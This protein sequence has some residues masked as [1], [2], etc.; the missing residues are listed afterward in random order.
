MSVTPAVLFVSTLVKT[1][2][3]FLMIQEGKNNYNQY[4]KWN[5]PSGHVELG[6]TM[7][8]AAIREVKEE[9]GYDVRLD[10]LVT[11]QKKDFSDEIGLV[12]FFAGSLLSNGRTASEDD[13]MNIDF[14]SIKEIE[15]ID[16][17]FPDL[18][19][20]AKI[21][22]KGQIYP[23]EIITQIDE[24]EEELEQPDKEGENDD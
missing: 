8:E 1:D 6:E 4:G 17:R 12:I 14:L 22:D 9:T 11:V 16:L 5:F 10:G 19:K 3:G 7:A 24:A 15:D 20:V 2:E 23:L 21:A 13:I 18:L